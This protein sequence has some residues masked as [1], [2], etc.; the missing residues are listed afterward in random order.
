LRFVSGPKG[1]AQKKNLL[2]TAGEKEGGKIRDQVGGVF[3]PLKGHDDS[4]KHGGREG[5]KDI[6]G[7]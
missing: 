2:E 7:T 1:T 5:V 4:T 6:E 3:L